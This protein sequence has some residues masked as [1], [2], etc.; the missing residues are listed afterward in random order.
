MTR[1]TWTSPWPTGTPSALADILN[2]MNGYD[3]ETGDVD[4][5]GH[6]GMLRR[7]GKGRG[8]YI[9]RTD[10]QGFKS[11]DDYG[12]DDD[13][14]VAWDAVTAEVDSFYDGAVEEYD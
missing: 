4:G 3:A 11:Y 6:Y 10:S 14:R 2:G 8:G 13:L 9:V 1:E 5:P 7:S 12:T